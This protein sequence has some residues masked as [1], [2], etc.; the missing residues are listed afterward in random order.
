MTA[1]AP[2]TKQ[3]LRKRMRER[4]A[5]LTVNAR[6]L[7]SSQIRDKI[8][9][10]CQE[11]SLKSLGIYLATPLE[12]AMD[13]LI[14]RMQQLGV[15]MYAP[16]FQDASEP[17][18]LLTPGG[19]NIA[20]TAYHALQLRAPVEFAN[21]KSAQANA[22]DAI[23]VPGLAFDLDGNRLGQGGGWYDRALAEGQNS[24]KIG[25]AFDCQVQETH[26]PHESHDQKM[27][28]LVTE[29]RFIQY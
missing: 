8:L 10:F 21:G 25:V 6:A 20:A 16:H 2:P 28:Y 1:P 3:D 29:S 9:T 27:D 17:F 15:E 14:T 18:Y 23:L 11:K 4:R 12:P 5:T 26:I 24:L 19:D 7:A 22:L 13:D